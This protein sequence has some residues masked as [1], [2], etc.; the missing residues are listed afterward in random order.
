[1]AEISEHTTSADYLL[2]AQSAGIVLELYGLSVQVSTTERETITIAEFLARVPITTE[3]QQQL[4][5]EL[6]KVENPFTGR[7]FTPTDPMASFWRAHPIYDVQWLN[8]RVS[9]EIVDIAASHH[10]ADSVSGI[11]VNPRGI[12]LA[13][14]D[15]TV[16]RD[17]FRLMAMD[18]FD[19]FMH[20][21]NLPAAEA[22][23]ATANLLA[24]SPLL[25]PYR[26]EIDAV[27]AELSGEGADAEIQK[28]E[29]RSV[30]S[31]AKRMIEHPEETV[32]VQTMRIVPLA[33]T[34][35]SF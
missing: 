8:G 18:K 21:G 26:A 14:V 22:A 1:M 15:P 23:A 5:A 7:P 11:A 32:T 12:D 10:L 19:A 24:K 25:T 4:L 9:N 20:R 27:L 29:I 13:T 28:Q 33:P 3:R 6:G 30:Q 16:R 31:T 2:Q 35:V 17:I 34:G